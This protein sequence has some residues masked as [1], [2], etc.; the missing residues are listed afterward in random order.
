MDQAYA[1][2]E[3]E[4]TSGQ[5]VCL[6]TNTSIPGDQLVSKMSKVSL[7][8][9]VGRPRKKVEVRNVFD[10]KGF[11]RGKR[12]AKNFSKVCKR[13]KSKHNVKQPPSV[14]EN[15][16]EGVL[17]LENGKDIASQ[18]LKTAEL[19]GLVLQEDKMQ[20]YEKIQQVLAEA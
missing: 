11:K 15:I 1:R 12:G 20:A 10:I 8:K 18:I 14:E 2:A 16:Q 19:M 6:A 17:L 5:E 4:I 13:R 3:G 7:G 9:K